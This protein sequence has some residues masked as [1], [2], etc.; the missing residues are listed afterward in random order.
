MSKIVRF[1]SDLSDN[2]EESEF[3]THS[4]AALMLQSE[5]K[6]E[7]RAQRVKEFDARQME[8]LVENLLMVLEGPAIGNTAQIR[9]RKQLVAAV[10]AN[11]DEET[12]ETI[13]KEIKVEV[14]G[15]ANADDDEPPAEDA[16]GEEGAPVVPDE[17]GAR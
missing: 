11:P 10:D 4:L 8:R 6:P 5:L 1:L 13:E 16:E 9:L 14:E 2:I 15:E 17:E 7:A 12:F 3:L